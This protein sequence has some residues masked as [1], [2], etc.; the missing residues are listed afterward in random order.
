MGA[1]AT[2]R[3]GVL[4][5]ILG[6]ALGAAAPRGVALAE[7]QSIGVVMNIRM[8]CPLARVL[9]DALS[10]SVKGQ[11]AMC[12]ALCWSQ[13]LGNTQPHSTPLDTF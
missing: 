6:V 4:S 13:R 10:S 9:L 2:G 5:R 3:I 11:C 1:G 12:R 8:G 7:I